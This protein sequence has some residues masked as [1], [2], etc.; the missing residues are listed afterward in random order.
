MANIILI[1]QWV[2]LMERSVYQLEK[3]IN[4]GDKTE[5]NRLRT[6]IFDLHTKIDSELGGKRNV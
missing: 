1:G 2:D 4:E 6:L 3:A 5:V